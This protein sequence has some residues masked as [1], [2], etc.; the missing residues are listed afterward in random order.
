MTPVAADLIRKA[1]ETLEQ[2]EVILKAGVPMVAARHHRVGVRRPP[3]R[4]S[5]PP[6]TRLASLG[7][8]SRK[9]GEGW[10]RRAGGGRVRAVTPAEAQDVIA[11][12]KDFV[13][14]I[15]SRLE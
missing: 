4:Y 3:S 11:K 15:E 14:R 10:T 1:G 12:A 8:L 7:T 5:R 13:A 2:A 6:L 9:A